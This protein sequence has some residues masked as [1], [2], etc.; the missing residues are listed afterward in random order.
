[1]YNKH[2]LTALLALMMSFALFFPVFAESDQTGSEI[3]TAGSET[4]V[5][6]SEDAD[7]SV[8]ADSTEE[9]SEGESAKITDEA[10]VAADAAAA[11]DTSDGV[12][13]DPDVTEQAEDNN[14]E[15]EEKEIKKLKNGF[16]IDGVKYIVR[17]KGQLCFDDNGGLTARDLCGSELVSVTSDTGTDGHSKGEPLNEDEVMEML[18]PE[19]TTVTF[20]FE[21]A[22]PDEA[23]FRGVPSCDAEFDNAA[24]DDH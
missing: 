10:S 3:N 1:M 16:E 2:G 11:T 5:T 22:E 12:C 7:G 23:F 9:V 24:I 20:T 21:S 4:D 14:T 6:A 17:G 19:G 18:F 8:T 13:E 15:N